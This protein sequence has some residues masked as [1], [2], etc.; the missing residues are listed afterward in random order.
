MESLQKASAKN[1]EHKQSKAELT[2]QLN[3]S[4]QQNTELE[5]RLTLALR[6]KQACEDK[7]D[8]SYFC[9]SMHGLC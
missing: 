8:F 6:D 7:V 3:R 5:R 1:D 4:Q 9:D 2:F